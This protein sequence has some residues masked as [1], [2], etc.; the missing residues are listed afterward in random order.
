M[1]Q[2]S[3]AY[4]ADVFTK[5]LMTQYKEGPPDVELARAATKACE[6]ARTTQPPHSFQTSSKHSTTTE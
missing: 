3:R 1:D 5:G 4:R 6:D 2:D